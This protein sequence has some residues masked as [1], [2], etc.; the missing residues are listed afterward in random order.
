MMK[1]RIP[2]NPKVDPF[3]APAMHRPSLLERADH[4][5]RKGTPP[6]RRGVR[7]MLDGKPCATMIPIPSALN[8]RL[9]IPLEKAIP[10]KREGESVFQQ[11]IRGEM[12]AMKENPWWPVATKGSSSLL[13]GV[14]PVSCTSVPSPTV[15]V[16][17]CAVT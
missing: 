6:V 3:V 14:A 13:S 2:R 5:L 4:I 8:P 15:D 10:K 11:H 1:P 9:V 17:P 12:N 7:A 16:A